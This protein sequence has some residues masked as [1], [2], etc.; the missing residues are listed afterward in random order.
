MPRVIDSRLSRLTPP[1][2]GSLV[3]AVT[4]G[5]LETIHPMEAEGVD[6]GD[7]HETPRVPFGPMEDLHAERIFGSRT[8]I[9]QTNRFRE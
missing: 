1:R 9:E 2:P 5:V 7:A 3:A 4:F 8:S 6:C